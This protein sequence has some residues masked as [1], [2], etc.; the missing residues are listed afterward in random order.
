LIRWLGLF[1]KYRRWHKK[2]ERRGSGRGGGE[3]KE[4][5]RERKT[6]IDKFLNGFMFL[7]N[8]AEEQGKKV[9]FL[10]FF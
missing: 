9:F 7:G 2:I 10:L 3:R 5:T 8:I 4:R 1:N 6:R